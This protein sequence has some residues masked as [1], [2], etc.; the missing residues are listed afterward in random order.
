[1]SWRSAAEIERSMKWAFENASNLL[2][3]TLILQAGNDKLVDK[4]TNRI[5]F[6]T[7]KSTDKTYREY[8]GLLHELWQ[9]KMRAQVFQDMFIWLEKH[10]KSKK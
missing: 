4:R 6:E 9:E 10:I 8:D 3:P 2:C 5:F 7:I 1:M